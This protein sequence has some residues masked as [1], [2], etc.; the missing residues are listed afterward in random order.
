VSPLQPVAF[1]LLRTRTNRS[2]LCQRL[3]KTIR[4]ADFSRGPILRKNR[5]S[6][7]FH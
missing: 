2:E 3:G 4:H 7:A 6:I 5:Q 1:P